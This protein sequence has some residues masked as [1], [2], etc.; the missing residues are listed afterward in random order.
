MGKSTR[1]R[2]FRLDFFTTLSFALTPSCLIFPTMNVNC[3]QMAITSFCLI[4]ASSAT[5]IITWLVSSHLLVLALSR[6]LLCHDKTRWL[7]CCL[8]GNALSDFGSIFYV[9]PLFPPLPLWKRTNNARHFFPQRGTSEV[10]RRSPTFRNETS[11]GMTPSIVACM[12][13]AA[14]GRQSAA[15]KPPV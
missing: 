2:R 4:G 11:S 5:C 14:G 7:V 10:S 6:G 3:S 9:R 1:L 15:A 13:G 8:R 12:R